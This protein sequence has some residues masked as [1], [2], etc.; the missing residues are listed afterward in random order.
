[1]PTPAGAMCF[2]NKQHLVSSVKEIGVEA[3]RKGPDGRELTAEQQQFLISQND[4]FNMPKG[5]L[6]TVSIFND[7]ATDPQDFLLFDVA[8]IAEASGASPTGAD[9]EITT[10][11][12]GGVPYPALQ[13]WMVGTHIGSIGTMFDFSDVPM[14]SSTNIKIW[15]GNIEDYN[16][17]SL[18]N[19][20]QLARDT[21]ANDQKLLVMKTTLYLNS[22]LAISGTLPAQKQLDILFNVTYFSNF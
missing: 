1:M 19:Y 22:F 7:H 8:G 18:K 13:M 2:T 10:T 6:L 5:S 16:A 3:G 12:A 15:N 17:K 20:F 9:I 21:Y 4:I 14:I 11:F